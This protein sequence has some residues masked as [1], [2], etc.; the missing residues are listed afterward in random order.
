MKSDFGNFGL[1][2]F[3]CRNKT[4]AFASDSS[5]ENVEFS[6][7]TL[8]EA[9]KAVVT[10]K[11]E[12]ECT[13]QSNALAFVSDFSDNQESDTWHKITGFLE[14]G[15]SKVEIFQSRLSRKRALNQYRRPFVE[16]LDFQDSEA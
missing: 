10:E 12:F 8:I 6:N 15:S 14:I 7:S 13:V 9:L 5:C 2:G 1:P 16:K 11:H 4:L 3:S